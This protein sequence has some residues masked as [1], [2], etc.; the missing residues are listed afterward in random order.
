MQNNVN[1]PTRIHIHSFL[2]AR[3]PPSLL[4]ETM[5]TISFA[6]CVTSNSFSS[7]LTKRADI[8]VC[9]LM[10]KSKSSISTLG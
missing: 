6:S 2:S 8:T 5:L 7:H 4:L 10:P 9:L 1:I 3:F